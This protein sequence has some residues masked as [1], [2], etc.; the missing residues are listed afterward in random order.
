MRLIGHGRGGGRREEVGEDIK[1]GVK[2]RGREVRDG[3]VIEIH[4]RSEDV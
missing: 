1:D 2:R 4:E 3:A